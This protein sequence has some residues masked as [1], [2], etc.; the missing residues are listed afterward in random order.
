MSSLLSRDAFRNGTFARDHHTCVVKGCKQKAQDAHHITERRLFTDPKEF[1]GYFLNNGASV[2]G[3]HHQWGAELCT[4]QPQ[5]LRNWAGI[6][7]IQLPLRFNSS[8]SYDKWGIALKRPNRKKIKYQSTPFLPSSP[9][10]EPNDINLT[11]LE[12]FV[13]QPLIVSVKMD[14]SN[15]CLSKDGIAARNGDL[16]NHPQFSLLKEMFANQWKGL[17]PDGI[18][19]FGEWLFAKHSIFYDNLD[20]YLQ[21]F[22]VYDQQQEMHLSW[23]EVKEWA[24]T[25]G[26]PTVPVYAEGVTIP[27]LKQLE[28]TVNEWT[29]RSLDENHEGIVIRLAYPFPYGSFESYMTTNGKTSWRVAAIAKW[30][31][32]N[33]VQTG[34]DWKKQKLV[35]NQ[36]L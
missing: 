36:L 32:P 27:T 14:G 19:I 17:I 34:E 28:R 5:V 25:L 3:Y 1:G 12:P 7:S 23:E 35:K 4:I 22:G 2:C 20:S 31:R 15:V 33:H 18:Q 8:Q 21:V 24:N 16:A 30:V 11:T 29:C 9:G 26:V 13:N 6:T 10:N